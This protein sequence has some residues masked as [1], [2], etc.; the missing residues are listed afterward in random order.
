MSSA[1]APA[2]QIGAPEE[3]RVMLR[4]CGVLDSTQ[5]PEVDF[6]MGALQRATDAVSAGVC[7]FD[8]PHASVKSSCTA[9]GPTRPDA[10]IAP[11]E[12]PEGGAGFSPCLSGMPDGGGVCADEPVALD[13][14]LIGRVYIIGEADR[15][16]A[17]HD[18]EASSVWRP[19]PLLGHWQGGLPRRP[20][21]N[22]V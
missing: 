13:G 5:L 14:H 7:F 10:A 4:L 16:W 20:V 22:L 1:I 9:S 15:L 17:E 19:L 2:E 12:P 21:T 3:L 8:G 6:W 18:L 11:P